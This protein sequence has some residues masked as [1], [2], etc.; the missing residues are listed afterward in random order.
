MHIERYER[1]AEHLRPWQRTVAEWAGRM[2]AFLVLAYRRQMGIRRREGRK[3][4]LFSLTHE[5][6]KNFEHRGGDGCTKGIACL[7]DAFLVHIA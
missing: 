6:V 4:K 2:F 3:R 7:P 5:A 1:F